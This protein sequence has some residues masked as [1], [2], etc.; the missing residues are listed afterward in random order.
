MDPEKK[1][2]GIEVKKQEKDPLPSSRKREENI[3]FVPVEVVDPEKKPSGIVVRSQE[4]RERSSSFKSSQRKYPLLKSNCEEF[5][6]S[7][8]KRTRKRLP[9]TEVLTLS[10]CSF[11]RS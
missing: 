4:E 6:R 9:T 1:P 3:L 2:S 5:F 10:F 8:S 7:K 11:Y